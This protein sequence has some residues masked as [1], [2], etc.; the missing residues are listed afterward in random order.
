MPACWGAAAPWLSERSPGSEVGVSAWTGAMCRAHSQSAPDAEKWAFCAKPGKSSPSLA[1]PIA[2]DHRQ[3]ARGW[4]GP[5]SRQKKARGEGVCFPARGL[6][7]RSP[8]LRPAPP[9][10]VPRAG[11]AERRPLHSPGAGTISRVKALRNPNARDAGGALPRSSRKSGR[12][13][14]PCREEAGS[15]GVARRPGHLRV[16]LITPSGF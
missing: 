16:D 12:G 6:R 10:S 9:L 13:P 8:T 5:G 4:P 7:R 15:V 11:R 1:G 2:Q 14:T 3:R